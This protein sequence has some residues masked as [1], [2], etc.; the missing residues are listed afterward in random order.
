MML[1]GLTSFSVGVYLLA[2]GTNQGHN[3]QGQI[4]ARVKPNLGIKGHG[5]FSEV[6]CF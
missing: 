3:S 2:D 1:E 4:Q 5:A 6:N